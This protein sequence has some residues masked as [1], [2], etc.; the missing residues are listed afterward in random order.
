MAVAGRLPRGLSDCAGARV[1]GRWLCIAVLGVDDD[2][3]RGRGLCGKGTNVV[4]V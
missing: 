2:G 4:T 1:V 3:R